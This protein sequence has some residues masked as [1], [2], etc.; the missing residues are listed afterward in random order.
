[1]TPPPERS[2]ADAYRMAGLAAMDRYAPNTFRDIDRA[3]I[4]DKHGGTNIHGMAL[5]PPSP[6]EPKAWFDTIVGETPADA[7]VNLG[8]LA[9]KLPDVI[10]AIDI[11]PFM[12]CERGAFALDGL[13]VLRPAAIRTPG[14]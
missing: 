14:V 9:H 2:E 4:M 10:E 13:V 12:V 11:N 1:M 7:L 6:G 8:R 5:P 3:E